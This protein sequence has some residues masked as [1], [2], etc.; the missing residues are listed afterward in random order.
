MD[1]EEGRAHMWGLL[2]LTAA[3]FLRTQSL[4][5][6]EPSQA[7]PKSGLGI[8]IPFHL[9]TNIQH[10]VDSRGDVPTPL[11]L[12]LT[13]QLTQEG[14]VDDTVT[15]HV[16]RPTRGGVDLIQCRNEELV[17]VLLCVPSQFRR[18]PPRGG[19]K[20]DWTIGS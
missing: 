1:E 8:L 4:R 17:G 15:R 13:L 10:R 12:Y 16:R 6:R 5:F 11:T 2:A 3:I 18:S 19:Q 7:R 14:R 20:R 9:Q